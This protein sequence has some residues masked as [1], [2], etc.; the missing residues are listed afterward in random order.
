MDSTHKLLKYFDLFG[1][2]SFNKKARR[3]KLG[4]ELNAIGEIKSKQIIVKIE[5]TNKRTYPKVLDLET[6]NF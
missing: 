3:I 5:F 6:P 2:E 4:I 1:Q